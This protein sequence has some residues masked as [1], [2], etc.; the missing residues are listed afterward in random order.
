MVGSFN[1]FHIGH[2]NIA[3]KAKRIF[4]EVWIVYGRNYSKEDSTIIIPGYLPQNRLSEMGF[5]V[6]KIENMSTPSYMQWL[7][8]EHYNNEAQIT[9]VRGIRNTTDLQQEL[10]QYRYMQSFDP[11]ID[12]ISIFCDSE[13]SHV[14][15]TGIR[16]LIH[17]DKKEAAKYLIGPCEFSQ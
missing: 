3:Q 15:S 12:V 17:I 5:L 11:N 10:T 6:D 9:L 2:L 13:L 4:D 7:N 8:Q 14:S 16:Q 1:P